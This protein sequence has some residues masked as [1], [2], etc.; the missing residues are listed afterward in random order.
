MI[1]S[2]WFLCLELEL[3]TV[4]KSTAGFKCCSRVAKIF[5]ACAWARESPEKLPIAEASWTVQRRE[6]C[7]IAWSNYALGLAPYIRHIQS[8]LFSAKLLTLQGSREAATNYIEN[9]INEISQPSPLH[10]HLRIIIPAPRRLR[11]W[12]HN[13]W[14]WY[15]AQYKILAATSRSYWGASCYRYPRVFKHKFKKITPIPEFSRDNLE[16]SLDAN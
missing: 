15:I 9:F 11:L 1:D 4:P 16:I 5:V 12:L 13:H 6:N 8:F 10:N 7:R 14:F 3:K 2:E